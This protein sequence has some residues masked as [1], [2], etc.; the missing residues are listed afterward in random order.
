M[1]K[2]ASHEFYEVDESSNQL[3][4][5]IPLH[6][7]RKTAKQNKKKPVTAGPVT[8]QAATPLPDFTTPVFKPKKHDML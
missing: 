3:A 1:K 5:V 8:Q 6:P 2:A 4:V 7:A